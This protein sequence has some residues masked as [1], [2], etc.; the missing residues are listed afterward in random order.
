MKLIAVVS[1]KGGTGKTVI[2][3]HLAAS[4]AK[5]GSRVLILELGHNFRNIDLVFGEEDNILYNI[6]DVIKGD[7]PVTEAVHEV[8]GM[9]GLHILPCSFIEEENAEIS[10]EAVLDILV[11]CRDNY[12]YVFFDG[13]SLF[14]L[15]VRYLHE[16]LVITTPD[17]FSI[18]ASARLCTSLRYKGIYSLHLIINRIPRDFIPIKGIFDYDDIIDSIGASLI[19]TIPESPRLSL[20]STL[21]RRLDEKSITPQIFDNI[22]DRICGKETRLLVK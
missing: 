19:G 4:F 17:A 20:S 1:G 9:P 11:G 22:A 6:C 16:A 18:R 3:C 15:P 2:T 12:D 8:S 13:G 5:K 14:N 21:G 10:G 7:I